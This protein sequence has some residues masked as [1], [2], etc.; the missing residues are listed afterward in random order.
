M[1]SRND[2]KVSMVVLG[3]EGVGKSSLCLRYVQDEFPDLHNPSVW[4]DSYTKFV[5]VG[6]KKKR[7]VQ[8][9]IL[10]TAGQEEMSS[11]LDN[12]LQN[13]DSVLLVVSVSDLGSLDRAV[14]TYESIVTY[15]KKHTYKDMSSLGHVT[16][17]PIM[18][19][20]NKCDLDEKSH[21]FSKKDIEDK[22]CNY[23]V[24]VIYTSAKERI[25]VEEAFLGAIEL[26]P[27]LTETKKGGMLNKI[28]SVFSKSK[29]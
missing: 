17:L 23:K 11:L 2:P 29:E 24:K 9:D 14:K 10:D 5:G 27:K 22:L 16:P 13:K 3:S 7:R 1:G 18:I 19:A 8:L 26:I 12:H 20:C 28:T 21:K 6:K 4:S 25:R 15:Y